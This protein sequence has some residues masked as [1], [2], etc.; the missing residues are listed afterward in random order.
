MHMLSLGM[1]VESTTDD[2]D[3]GVWFPLT[4]NMAL[5][6]L[7]FQTVHNSGTSLGTNV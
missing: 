6:E 3:D 1:R 7:Q 5:A 4:A 2:E